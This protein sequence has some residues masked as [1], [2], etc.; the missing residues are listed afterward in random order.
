V[1]A[2]ETDLHTTSRFEGVKK[3]VQVLWLRGKGYDVDYGVRILFERCPKDVVSK[4]LS[5]IKLSW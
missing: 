1:G 3:E 4:V 2:R 5:R